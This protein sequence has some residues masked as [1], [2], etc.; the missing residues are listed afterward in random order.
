MQKASMRK[1][2][3]SNAVNC[4]PCLIM[5]RTPCLI[6]QPV[7]YALCSKYTRFADDQRISHEDSM[8]CAEST[9]V[10][11]DCIAGDAEA[12][13]ISGYSQASEQQAREASTATFGGEVLCDPQPSRA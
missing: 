1:A 12:I 6:S 3:F 9:Q 7:L 5:Q 8:P 13:V 4:A 10:F 2:E 11:A